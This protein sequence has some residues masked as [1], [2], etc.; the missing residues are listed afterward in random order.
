M[1]IHDVYGCWYI[2]SQETSK[3]TLMMKQRDEAIHVRFT[4]HYA[5]SNLIGQFTWLSK[6]VDL[7]MA[8]LVI[9]ATSEDAT[10]S[11]D[12]RHT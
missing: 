6:A 8:S 2:C 4:S 5:S 3:C 10:A 12:N 7:A 9:A 1:Y 11:G